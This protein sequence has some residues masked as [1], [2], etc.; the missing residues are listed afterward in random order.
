MTHRW[1]GGAWMAAG[2]LLLAVYFAMGRLSWYS[3]VLTSALL[4]V[5]LPVSVLAAKQEG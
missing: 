1:G 2:L 5:P 4:A 3:A